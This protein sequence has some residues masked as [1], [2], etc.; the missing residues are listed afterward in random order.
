MRRRILACLW[1][2]ILAGCARNPP[3]SGT[4][5][6]VPDARAI[7]ERVS[8]LIVAVATSRAQL[9]ST[10]LE[11]H[12]MAGDASSS[13]I[14]RSRELR[15][16]A[17][18]LDSTYRTR[19]AELQSTVS[20]A[21][22]GVATSSARFP[23]ESPRVPFVRAFAGGEHWMLQS[24]LI[25]ELG[26][27]TPYRVI[28]VP[29]GFVT[30]FASIPKPLQMLRGLLPTTERYGTAALIHDYLYWRQDCTR[31]QSDDIMEIAMME[32]GVPLL[33]R[34]IIREGVRQFGQ[35]AW[36]ANRRARE[37]G[38]VKIVGP[39]HDQVPPTGTWAE[40]R[41]WLRTIRAKEGMEYRVH[42]S[43]CAMADSVT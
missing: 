21:T 26:K 3:A 22:A 27:N 39:P 30:D 35:S 11:I 33:E 37:S 6:P 13:A 2:A 24:P 40:Y 42:E 16:R 12:R 10:V 18:S 17:A 9:D 14:S 31:E 15:V 19:L 36:D 25:L 5:S 20:A 28:I 38:L 29:R 4:T 23:I 34:R 32:T 7:A 41:E 1:A 43:V 8:H